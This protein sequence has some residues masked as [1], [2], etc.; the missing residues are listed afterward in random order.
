MRKEKL[1]ELLN[2]IEGNPEILLWSGLVG[3]YFQLDKLTIGDLTKY[4]L[5]YYTSM[6][7]FERK[8][9][10]QDWSYKLTTAEEREI[11]A[12]YRNIDWSVNEFVCV[13]DIREGRHKRKSAVFIEVKSRGIKTFDRCGDVSY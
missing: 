12:A 7:E 13:E 2:A 4:T 8:R 6:Y 3:D 1:I 11:K 5:K 10:K 9:D